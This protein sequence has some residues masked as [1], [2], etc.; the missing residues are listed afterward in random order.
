[1]SWR[2]KISFWLLLLLLTVLLQTCKKEEFNRRYVNLVEF[3]PYL[4]RVFEEDRLTFSDK[5]IERSGYTLKGFKKYRDQLPR[6]WAMEKESTIVA[7]FGHREDKTAV[8]RCRPFNPPGQPHQE[9][10]IFI[11]HRFL[12]KLALK[13]KDRYRFN[14]PANMLQYGSNHITFKWKYLR[15]PVDFGINEDKRKYAVGFSNLE[16]LSSSKKYIKH[17]K[18]TAIRLHK[19]ARKTNVSGI[20]IPQAG[21]VEYYVRLPG[22]GHLK[23][24][25]ST[26]QGHLKNSTLHVAVYDRTGGQTILPFKNQHFNAAKEHIVDLKP[27]ANRVVKVVFANSPR[28]HPNFVVSLINPTIF[29]PAGQELPALLA[30]DNSGTGVKETRPGGVKEKKTKK[31]NVFIY[32]IDTLRADHLSC[33]G[34]SRETSPNIDQFA[35]SGVLFKNCFASASWTK[36][37]V[38]SILTGLYPDKHKAEDKE[39]KLSG[40]VQTLSEVLKSSG[41]TTIYITPNLNASGD[42][43]FDQGNDYYKFSNRSNNIEN[44]YHSS[45]IVNSEFAEILERVPNYREKPLFAYLHTVDPHDPYTPEEPFLKFKKPGVQGE[46]LGFPDEIRMKKKAGGL[47][48]D[49][50]DYIKGL[51]DCEILHN[52]H[53]FGKFLDFLK[54]KGLYENSIIILVSDHGEQFDEHGGLFHGGSIYNQEVHVPL[55][56]KFPHGERAGLQTEVIVSQVDIFPTILG[57]LGLAPSADVDGVS[58]LD[59]VKVG[60]TRRSVFIKQKRNGSRKNNFAGIINGGNWHKHIITYKDKTFIDAS[61]FELYDLGRDFAERDDMLDE[62]DI[63]RVGFVKFFAD[64]FLTKAGASRFKEEKKLDY[65]KIDPEKIKQLKALG[66]LN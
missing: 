1:M 53:Y 27:F 24:R 21:L 45:E 42:V 4:T 57:V 26:L 63:F 54:V 49:D 40:E 62:R 36:P 46:R 8:L 2:Q 31:P 22:N 11:N 15:A 17:K 30:R 65:K 48:G 13:E 16:F 39:D 55:I 35:K 34:Y 28:N 5:D 6:T 23:F 60:R 56:V 47:S 14:I 19:P 59:L 64:Y 32:L 66:Y 20:D 7:Y 18:V 51:Y 33:Y 43:N 29:T 58:L 25:L 10:D 12:K 9:A 38:G 41:Y 61:D 37:C 44:F 50:I 52:D 3:F